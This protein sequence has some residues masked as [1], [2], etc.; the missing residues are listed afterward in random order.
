MTMRKKSTQARPKSDVE[1][2][3]IRRREQLLD[4]A[5]ANTFPASDPPSWTMGRNSALEPPPVRSDPKTKLPRDSNR[6]PERR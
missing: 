6:R 3:H 1:N 4:E 2:E 5:L